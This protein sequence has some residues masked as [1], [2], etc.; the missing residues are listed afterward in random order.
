MTRLAPS[1]PPQSEDG[2]P[3]LLHAV[4]RVGARGS[5]ALC[6]HE[7]TTNGIEG[8]VTFLSLIQI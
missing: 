2:T 5:L 6:L 3:A 7:Q 4:W 8:V 1:A